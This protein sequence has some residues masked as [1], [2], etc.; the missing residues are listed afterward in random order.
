MEIYVNGFTEK[1]ETKQKIQR[2]KRAREA[3]EQQQR[4]QAARE[5]LRRKNQE[6]R[7]WLMQFERKM[8]VGL[9][10]RLTGAR[11][12][13]GIFYERKARGDVLIKPE[14]AAGRVIITITKEQIFNNWPTKLFWICMRQN[15]ASSVVPLP[16]IGACTTSS[17]TS[18][19]R[20][21]NMNQGTNPMSLAEERRNRRRGH[22]RIANRSR[23]T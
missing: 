18:L 1:W 7:Q 8:R 2:E 16:A 19:L 21:R 23:L 15:T 4:I 12:L 13:N 14:G 6:I 17:H 20:R 3:R 9:I 10:P 5:A 11:Y 22:N